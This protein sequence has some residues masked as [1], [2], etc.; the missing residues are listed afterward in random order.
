MPSKSESQHTFMAMSASKKGRARLK[1]M[2]K[3]PAPMSV[4]KEFLAADA[5][6]PKESDTMDVWLKKRRAQVAKHHGIH[7]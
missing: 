3:K 2:G 7:R 6:E 4:A 5:K 1:A